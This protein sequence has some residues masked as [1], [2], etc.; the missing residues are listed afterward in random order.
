[1]VYKGPIKTYIYS[2]INFNIY[3]YKYI[4]KTNSSIFNLNG[5]QVYRK[6][7]FHCRFFVTYKLTCMFAGK[8][9]FLKYIKRLYK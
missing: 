1:M 9:E 7:P 4:Y 5:G 6:D 2:P 8:K 3:Y